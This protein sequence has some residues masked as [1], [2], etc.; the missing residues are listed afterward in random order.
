MEW[1]V[2]LTFLIV[3]A[4]SI[5]GMQVHFRLKDVKRIKEQNTEIAARIAADIQRER[6]QIFKEE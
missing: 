2:I 6:E 4:L 1:I 3:I 5:V